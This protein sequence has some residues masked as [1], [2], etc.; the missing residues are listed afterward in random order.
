MRRA[1]RKDANHN[2]VVA[3]MESLDWCVFDLSNYGAPVDAAVSK[4]LAWG[5]AV[6]VVEIKDGDKAPSKRKLTESAEKLR[7]RWKGPYL[8]VTSP[9]DAEQQL[10]KLERGNHDERQE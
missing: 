3:R 4:R 2:D 6:A 5:Y 1:Y 10:A 9:D 7:A 8:V